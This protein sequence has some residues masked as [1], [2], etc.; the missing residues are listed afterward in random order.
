MRDPAQ[1]RAEQK[2]DKDNRKKRPVS[3]RLDDDE[4]AKLDT[5]RGTR[6]RADFVLALVLKAIEKGKSK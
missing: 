3:F 1:I 2:Y 6:T 5:A 4:M